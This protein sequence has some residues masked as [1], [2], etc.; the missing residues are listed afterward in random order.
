MLSYF[1]HNAPCC[2][3]TFLCHFLY[4]HDITGCIFVFHST[5]FKNP[6]QRYCFCFIPTN[7]SV[8]CCKFCWLS[9]TYTSVRIA[10]LNC[11]I[12]HKT[13]AQNACASHLRIS[14]ARTHARIGVYVKNFCL[15]AIKKSK[16]L[17]KVT[18]SY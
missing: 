1:C 5:T 13:A 3:I 16:R 2:S 11:S 10:R 8:I 15:F 18:C 6:V 17:S 4:I 7:Q 12:A 9:R 14:L